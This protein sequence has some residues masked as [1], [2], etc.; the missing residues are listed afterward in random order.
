[1]NH[2]PKHLND[3]MNEDPFY[4]LCCFHR[5]DHGP[6]VRI[7]R[8]HNL[9]FAGKQVQEKWAILPICQA[10]HEKAN[11][12]HIRERLDW[13]MLN[14]APEERLRYYGKVINF[15]FRKGQ[16]NTQFGTYKKYENQKN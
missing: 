13:I 10:V 16:L 4:K 2:I 5:I 1:M 9:I 12:K 11:E 7:E 6:T 3:E 8:H 15:F 14:R